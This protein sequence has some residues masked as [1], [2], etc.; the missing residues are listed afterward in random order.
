MKT[1]AIYHKDCIDGTSAAAVVLRKFPDAL[2]F[3]MS[4]GYTPE[5]IEPIVKNAT[6]GDRIFTVD[7][8]MGVKEFLA[9]GFDITSI[10]HHIGA[11]DEYK[12]LSEENPKFTYIFDNDKSGA[13]LSWSYFFAKENVPEI[14]RLVED[15]D[16][17]RWK[18]SPDTENVNHCLWLLIN[19]PAEMGKLFNADKQTLDAIK[20]DGAAITKYVK[21]IMEEAVKDHE[22]LMFSIG[23]QK[24]PLYNV[25]AFKSEMGNI[26]AKERNQ[27]VGL[28]SIKNNEV[29]I[30]FRCTDSHNPTALDMA[31]ALGGGGH[32]NAA[33]AR[34][35]LSEFI[36]GIQH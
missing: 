11:H 19:Q 33:S 17:W 21:K 36:K 23:S 25:T 18:Y 7:C 9:A 32:R 3:P 28:F 15:R 35:S 5:E 22:P 31:K 12:K 16:L 14:I 2:L 13:S 29:R 27:S 20:R 24:V 30:S 1:I 26:L 34:I 10:D 8:V 4:H 6:Q